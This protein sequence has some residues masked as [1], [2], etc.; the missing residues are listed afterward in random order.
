MEQ[1]ISN[2]DPG[3]LSIVEKILLPL[4][5]NTLM[6]CIAVNSVWKTN[7]E[8]LHLTASFWLKKNAQNN[9]PLPS[10]IQDDLS[11]Y[12]SIGRITNFSPN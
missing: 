4:D 3:F 11:D 6:S 9:M 8:N 1:I 10:N 2:P 5:Y 7:L 12:D